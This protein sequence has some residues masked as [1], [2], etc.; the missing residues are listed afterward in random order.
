MTPQ[1]QIQALL[2]KSGIPAKEI[3]VYGSQIV[4]TAWSL[5]AANKWAS[6]IAKFATLRGG[7][8]ATTEDDKVN[9]NTVMKPSFHK[10][11]RVYARI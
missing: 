7:V 5:Q 11:W 6:L 9:T 4:I 10:V 1:E 8:L 3:Q 2:K